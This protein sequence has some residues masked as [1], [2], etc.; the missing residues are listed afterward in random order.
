MFME[1]KKKDE[2]DNLHLK[3]CQ[4]EM[5]PGWLSILG[6]ALSWQFSESPLEVN[7]SPAVGPQPVIAM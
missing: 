4:E 7:A 6:P 2:M 5:G 3:S 1:R